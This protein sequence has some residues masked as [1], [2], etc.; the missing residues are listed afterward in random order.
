MFLYF[1]VMN[2]SKPSF[3]VELKKLFMKMKNI[4]EQTVIVLQNVC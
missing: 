1:L 2:V 3:K 4:K